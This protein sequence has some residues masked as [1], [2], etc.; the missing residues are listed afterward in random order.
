MNP[1]SRLPRP[2][3]LTLIE[4]LTVFSIISLM[5]AATLPSFSELRRNIN[6]RAASYDLVSDLTAARSQAVKINRPVQ[7]IP[8]NGDWKNGWRVEVVGEAASLSRRVEVR[9]VT[10]TQAPA[11]IVFGGT[12]RLMQTEQPIRMSL[13]IDAEDAHSRCVQVELT[14]RVA[15][16]A[17]ACT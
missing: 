10:F 1:S 6:L 5:L 4:M 9:D 12:G 8:V 11:S 15:A 2:H 7:V 14:G 17:K 3:G 13:N 16:R